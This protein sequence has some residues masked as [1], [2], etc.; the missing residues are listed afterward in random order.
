MEKHSLGC[1]PDKKDIRDY[2]IKKG[3]VMA[4]QYP[5]TFEC[6]KKVKIKD[7]GSVGSCVAHSTAEI[8]EYHNS[9]DER[10]STNFIY[11]IHYKLFGSKGPGMYMREACKIAQKYGDPL[12]DLCRG[13]TEVDSVYQLAAK[14]FEKPEVLENASKHRISSYARLVSQNDIK[15]ALMEYGPVLSSITWYEENKVDKSGVLQ[16]G[17]TP[18]GGHAIMTYGWN[19]QG[20]LC[21]NSWGTYW[22]NKGY[23]RLPYDYKLTEA[24]SFV[25]ADNED[26]IV[27][28]STNKLIDFILK[29]INYIINLF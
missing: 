15:Y 3:L 27:K 28:P 2:K 12:Y 18:E 11:G 1:L 22:G 6:Q 25:P 10:L 29:L 21:Q 20:W 23:F 16:Q 13:N 8:L 26:D 5:T 4:L 14:A 19:E 17:I 9:N 24:Y 7:Q